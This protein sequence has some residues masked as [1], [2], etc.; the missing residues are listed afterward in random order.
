MDV[1]EL[2]RIEADNW[3]PPGQN[4][5][6]SFRAALRNAFAIG[7]RAG[8]YLAQQ[9][10]AIPRRADGFSHQ[11]PCPVCGSGDRSCGH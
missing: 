4:H 2:A 3:D 1:T 11:K 9:G 7:F 6:P 8:Y 10:N 5:G